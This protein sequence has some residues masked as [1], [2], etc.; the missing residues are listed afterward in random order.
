VTNGLYRCLVGSAFAI[1]NAFPC[2][3]A[4]RA[5]G[6]VRRNVT[7][8]FN[9]G[10]EI[11]ARPWRLQVAGRNDGWV[12]LLLES[13]PTIA[14]R[15]PW[16]VTQNKLTLAEPIRTRVTITSDV[17]AEMALTLDSLLSYRVTTG[18]AGD[19]VASTRLDS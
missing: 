18:R 16:L 11:L 2:L 8:Q 3:S 5:A 12:E 17:A 19:H 13:I 6:S 15:V 7:G 9:L 4:Q 10:P 1:L 14:P